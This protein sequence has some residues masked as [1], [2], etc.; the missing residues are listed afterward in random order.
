[1]KLSQEYIEKTFPEM[2][3]TCFDFSIG[4]GWL[5]MIMAFCSQH[6][7]TR[8]AQVKEKF[9][10]LRLYLEEGTNEAFAF[11]GTLEALSFFVCEAC[12][13]PAEVRTTGWIKTLCQSCGENYK[14]KRNLYELL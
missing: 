10:G 14:D 6:S 3:K 8:I 5:P 7:D 4:D 9:G 12:G 13:K 2:F 11:V 1:M